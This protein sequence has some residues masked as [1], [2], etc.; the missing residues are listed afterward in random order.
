[1]ATGIGPV[2]VAQLPGTHDLT[3]HSA[4]DVDY[5]RV[6]EV[7]RPSGHRQALVTVGNADAPVRVE[8]LTYDGSRVLRAGTAGHTAVV[9]NLE[10]PR[11]LVR[12]SG[13]TGHPTRDTVRLDFTVDVTDLPPLGP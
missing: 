7:P 5:F 12:V 8:V 10:P 9:L 3:L 2:V 13:T 1:V 4:S 6:E 11:C